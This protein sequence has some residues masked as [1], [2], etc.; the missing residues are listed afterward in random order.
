M[1]KSKSKPYK[2]FAAACAFVA[3]IAWGPTAAGQS[4]TVPL[5][6]LSFF[7]NPGKSWQLAADVTADLGK[8]NILHPAK[9]TGVLVN[10]PSK[11]KGQDLVS[12]AEYGDVDLELDFMMAK[13]S[14]SGVYLQ[15]RY[16]IQLEDSWGK[17]NR[18]ASSN[19][20]VY[21]RWDESRP[22]GLQGFQ[23][24]APRQNV[25]RAPGLWQHLKVS[26]QAPRF[27]ASG[28]KTENAKLLRVELNGVTIHENVELFGPTR[29]AISNTEKA[30]GPLRFQGDHGAVAFRN[31]LISHF[32][33]PRPVLTNLAYTIH[34]GRY[35]QSRQYRNLPPE[36]EGPSG[37][38]TSNLAYKSKQFLVRYTGT[39]QIKDAGD[40]TFN[41]NT[42]GGAGMVSI[43]NKEVVP[44]NEWDSKGSTT[45]PA[46]NIPFEL[47][48]TKYMDWAAPVLNLKVS[49]PGL[50]EFIISDTEVGLS[51]VVDP[52]LVD[53]QDK[54]VLRSF[55]DIP[56]NYRVT[57]AVS[58]GSP[59]Q[60]HYTYDMDHGAL[61]QLW[62]GGFIDA[63]PMWH[64]RGDGS[65]RPVGSVKHFGKPTLSIAKLTSEQAAWATDTTGSSY[66]QKGYSLT[67][68]EQ[69]TFLYEAYGVNVQDAIRVLENGQGLRREVNVQN[70]GAGL[71]MRLAEGSKIEEMPKGMYLVDDKAY[72]VKIEDAGGARPVVR[73][74]AG[75]QELIIPVKGKVA[76]SILF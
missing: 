49:G 24:Y 33:K 56:G 40:Y 10:M 30:T 38:L 29:G 73:T 19:G 25:S 42:P 47:L 71:Y 23:G 13:G 15:G 59:A 32:T 54:P 72:Y 67:T 65:S 39:L 14:N 37:I 64:E 18:S 16:E 22:K 31:I 43:N 55:M 9:G 48:Y 53:A 7:Q 66:R 27:D 45:L 75:R 36:A 46:G 69:P 57:H 44:M 63:T 8:A 60:L 3:G 1:L 26:F 50:R 70:N 21:E 20:G 5:H 52:I 68:D 58:V 74:V 11:N 61:V 12:V 76:Y 51:D 28:N 41:L 35:D 34:G 6:D 2:R 62:R 17:S 4:A